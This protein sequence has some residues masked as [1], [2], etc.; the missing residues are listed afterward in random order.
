MTVTFNSHFRYWL[1]LAC[2]LLATEAQAMNVSNPFDPDN[3][4]PDPIVKGS[5]HV[6]LTSVVSSGSLTAPNLLISAGD[7]TNRQFVTDQVGQVRLIKDGVLQSTPFLNVSARLSTLNPNYDERGLLGLAFSPTFSTPGTPGFGKLYTY[8][9]E[10]A[11]GQAD[12]T[13]PMPPGAAFNH[14]NVVAEWTVDPNNPDIVDPA[15]RRELMRVD[16][17]QMNHNGGML[18]FGPDDL[19]YIS[20]G[21]GGSGNDI[22][23]GHGATGNGR[24]LSN[25]LGD[26][27]R[28]DPNGAN[29]ANGQYGIPS[30]NP[31]VGTAGAVG[32]IYANGFRNPWRFSF[33]T[34]T[35]ALVEGETGQVTVEEVNLVTA[36]GNYGWNL[37]EGQFKFDPATGQVSNDLTGLPPGLINPVLQYDHTEGTAMI[38]GFVYRGDELPE[39]E[40]KYIFG[41]WGAFAAP[42]SRL[43]AGDLTTGAIEELNIENM[44]LSRWLLG[45]GQDAQGELYLLTSNSLGPAGLTGEIY[46]ISA[47]PLPAAVW[48]FGSGLAGLGWFNWRRRHTG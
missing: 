35:G 16:W 15:S 30:D 33:D 47:V 13:V 18:A 1:V 38:G 28:I 14:Q 23:P 19:L 4:F 6:N 29:S 2:I 7:G 40:G 26:I 25:P 27:L 9:S 48:L 21:D 10:P 44:T 46:K 24:D 3:P 22:G 8:T 34:Q 42:T 5:L 12:F 45:F 31:F 20:M 37:M 43:F 39:L 32:E 17:P 41:D 36:G 11:T